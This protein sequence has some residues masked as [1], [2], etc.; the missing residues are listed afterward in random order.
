M[1]EYSI[2]Q[3]MF[4]RIEE[5]ARAQGAV[6]VRHVKVRIGELAG[7]D[8]GLLQTAYETFRADTMC[9][10]ATLSVALVPARWCCPEGHGDLRPGQVLTCTRCGR[11][12]R[13]AAGDEIM[14][15]QLELEVP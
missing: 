3:A 9:D 2:V 12:A 10:R 8:V 11:A 13:L 4:E 1:H 6:A 5:A 15:E 7:V 14:L